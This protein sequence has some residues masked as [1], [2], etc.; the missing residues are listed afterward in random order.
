MGQE[1]SHLFSPIQIG[2]MHSR[3]R[4]HISPHQTLYWNFSNGL[5]TERYI[6]YWTARAKG[7]AGIVET[8]LTQVHYDKRFDHFRVPGWIEIHKRAADIVHKHG[9]KFICQIAN[10]GAQAGGASNAGH[11]IAPSAIPVTT[12]A[13]YQVIPHEMVKDEIKEIIEAFAYG[14]NSVKAA[15]A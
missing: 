15:G 14:A 5:P 2:N 9:A 8:Y 3:N 7:G 12:A 11:V 13:Q 1:F 6:N 10:M 4:I